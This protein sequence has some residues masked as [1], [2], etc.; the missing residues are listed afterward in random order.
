MLFIPWTKRTQKQ[1]SFQEHTSN[2]EADLIWYFWILYLPG[3]LRIEKFEAVRYKCRWDKSD[4]IG[5]LLIYKQSQVTAIHILF[6]TPYAGSGH[7]FFIQPQIQG[8]V[9]N[10]KKSAPPTNMPQWASELWRLHVLLPNPH[11]YHDCPQVSPVSRQMDTGYYRWN[12]SDRLSPYLVKNRW[13]SASWA[14]NLFQGS[15]PT[16]PFSRSMKSP[17]EWSTCCITRFC[18][19]EKHVLLDFDQSSN[20]NGSKDYSEI[21]AFFNGE[22]SE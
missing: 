3:N 5:H 4:S 14:V 16:R 10:N 13:L 9:Y 2:Q 18:I 8:R 7:C 11:T 15:Y 19:R 22:I 20:S 6:S 17:A 21:N 1:S 12:H